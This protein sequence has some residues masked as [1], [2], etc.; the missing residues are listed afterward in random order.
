MTREPSPYGFDPDGPPVGVFASLPPAYRP[1]WWL[2]GLLLALTLLTTTFFGALFAGNLPEQMVDLPLSR[3][4]V[5]PRFIS[6]GLKFSIPLLIILVSHELGHYIACRRHGLLATPPFFIPAPI[7]I[8]TFGAVIRIKEPI[9]N[10]M[11][12]LDIGAAGP[13][14]GFVVLIPFLVY[15]MAVSRVETLPTDHGFLFFG[16]PI[17]FKLI[18]HF[19]HP[20]IANGADIVLGPVGWAAWFGLLLTALNM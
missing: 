3:L 5:D 18:A 13:L 16:E 6:E 10:K 15:G 12:L 11:Q 2:H 17:L 1:R 20:H 7:G 8:G 4:V 9:R 14:T 19:F